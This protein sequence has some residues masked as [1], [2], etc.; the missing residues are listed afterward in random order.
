MWRINTLQTHQCSHCSKASLHADFVF[1]RRPCLFQGS[2]SGGHGA[3]PTGTFCFVPEVV[4]AVAGTC[5]QT[6]T[7]VPPVL[8]AGGVTDGRQVCS[9]LST[10]P[11]SQLSFGSCSMS[12]VFYWPP[13]SPYV[14]ACSE[15]LQD[16]HWDSSACRVGRVPVLCAGGLLQDCLCSEPY[17]RCSQSSTVLLMQKH[18]A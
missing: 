2:E 17:E 3:G 13:L 1:K 9:C 12:A 6:G 11:S 16:A 15:A 10:V 7:P 5:A 14:F 4:D 18:C 8:A